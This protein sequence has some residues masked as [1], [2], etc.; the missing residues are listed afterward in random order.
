MLFRGAAISLLKTRQYTQLLVTD[1][2][3]PMG[4][5]KKRFGEEKR[6]SS[7]TSS[8]NYP[9]RQLRW[10]AAL[11]K[12]QR[13]KFYWKTKEN[14]KGLEQVGGYCV[15]PRQS[16]LTQLG[17]G[18]LLFGGRKTRDT[19]KLQVDAPVCGGDNSSFLFGLRSWT[20]LL[21]CFPLPKINSCQSP[22]LGQG[23][24]TCAFPFG[25]CTKT[26]PS[27]FSN[28]LQCQ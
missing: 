1:P 3:Y 22:S 9:N 27:F 15:F 28:F 18:S 19:K 21:S 16:R 7:G 11:F 24:R 10:L 14:E 13:E 5:A 25:T 4:K 17:N 8:Q 12:S 26:P 6:V 2:T 20:P 23:S